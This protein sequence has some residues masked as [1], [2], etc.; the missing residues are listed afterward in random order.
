[1]IKCCIVHIGSAFQIAFKSPTISV[2]PAQSAAFGGKPVDDPVNAFAF[3][4]R[5]QVTH[6]VESFRTKI[7]IALLS[8]HQVGINKMKSS[9]IVAVQAKLSHISINE[10]MIYHAR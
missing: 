8:K 6:P 2:L 3:E 7:E 10:G 1:M 5:H 4:R 9:Y